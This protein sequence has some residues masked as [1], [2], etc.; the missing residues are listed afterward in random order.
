LPGKGVS[1][2]ELSVY[3]EMLNQLSPIENR[4]SKFDVDKRQVQLALT[5]RCGRNH[6]VSITF[7]E[8]YPAAQ[9]LITADL[10]EK[11]LPLS[12]NVVA[13]IDQLQ[14]IL[15]KYQDVWD[16]LDD[17][18]G[19]FRVTQPKNPS[20]NAMFRR[21]A[22]SETCALVMEI[23]P[24]AP[25]SIPAIQVLGSASEM[26]KY[27]ARLRSIADVWD[28][29]RP[30]RQNLVALFD[31]YQSRREECTDMDVSNI[32]SCS[33]CY[34]VM[35]EDGTDGVSFE[36]QECKKQFHQDCLLEWVQ[37]LP[38]T[39]RSFNRVFAGCPNCH[40][41]ITISIGE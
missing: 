8:T 1:K 35:V 16:M 33:I 37:T 19:N 7:P 15:E 11:F 13:C 25:R 32:N 9:L 2:Q 4:I 24:N 12:N 6:D 27:T 3:E 38:E 29:Q 34:D 14:F 10:P 40:Q 36:C 22:V 23:D 31:I 30:L 39:R 41:S 18:D 26:E 5:D 20:R 21:I 28:P 17:V